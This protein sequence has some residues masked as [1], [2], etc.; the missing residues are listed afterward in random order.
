MA[1]K[2]QLMTNEKEWQTVNGVEVLVA[3]DVPAWVLLNNL[4]DKI[5]LPSTS[6]IATISPLVS[7]VYIK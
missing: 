7:K 6:F 1:K 4:D 3:L 2:V 5:L